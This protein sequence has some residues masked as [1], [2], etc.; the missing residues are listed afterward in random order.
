MSY[1]IINLDIQ[2][3]EITRIA[4]KI[5]QY[6]NYT[7]IIVEGFLP[8]YASLSQFAKFSGEVLL[9]EVLLS[10][11]DKIL[12]ERN[13]GDPEPRRIM[14]EKLMELGIKVSPYSDDKHETLQ[15]FER[16]AKVHDYYTFKVSLHTIGS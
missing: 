2:G 8:E 9:K 3:S 6:T 13:D 7:E 5:S 10:W 14:A 12:K 4:E 16:L 1:F 11:H 15:K